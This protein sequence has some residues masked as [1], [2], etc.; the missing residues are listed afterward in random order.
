C[1]ALDWPLGSHEVPVPHADLTLQGVADLVSEFLEELGL[2]NVIV[3][4]ND[5]GGAITQ[6]LMVRRP[7]RIG[8][9]LLPPSDR[10]ERF[11]APPFA[12]L[13]ADS[14]LPGAVWLLYPAT[15]N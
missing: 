12:F 5:T 6:L 1:I 4:A 13:P 15:A 9:V 8:R 14:R 2:H 11:F 3:V 10:F 7:Q